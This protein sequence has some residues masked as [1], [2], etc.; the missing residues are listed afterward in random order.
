AVLWIGPGNS[1][2][3]AIAG[4]RQPGEESRFAGL[5]KD[6][7][8][9]VVPGELELDSVRAAIYKDAGGRGGEAAESAVVGCTHLIRQLH[10]FAGQLAATVIEVLGEQSTVA[11]KQ[12]LPPRRIG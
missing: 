1:E 9:T 6:L 2:P 11:Q 7:S 8:R 10:G 12:Y 3:G 4:K 5:A